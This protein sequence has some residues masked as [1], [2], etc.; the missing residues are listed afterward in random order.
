MHGDV[1]LPIPPFSMNDKSRKAPPNTQ[2]TILAARLKS[3]D[4]NEPEKKALLE[5]LLA[6]D[7]DHLRNAGIEP[8]E[9]K[10]L[11]K[12]LKPLP[13]QWHTDLRGV[14]IEGNKKFIN[15]ERWKEFLGDSDGWRYGPPYRFTH[16]YCVEAAEEKPPLKLGPNVKD[17]SNWVHSL[18]L[19]EPDQESI[20]K[21]KHIEQGFDKRHVPMPTH[22]EWQPFY[23]GIGDSKEPPFKITGL[24]VNGRPL[25]AKPDFILR[26]T[27][28]RII[29]IEIKGSDKTIPIDGWPDL[30]A[31]LWAYGQIDELR[32]AS[33]VL[34]IGEIWWRTENHLIRRGRVRWSRD[35]SQ[36]DTQNRELFEL[37]KGSSK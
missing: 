7:T 16:K 37:Y 33:A 34:L 15:E 18:Y 4:L 27:R 12:K 2:L 9:L 6:L 20:L 3:G 19:G 8:D 36:F 32:N 23:R 11:S 14:F 30:R 10:Y 26:D 25:L 1:L 35:D 29:V 17:F 31:Q 5:K 24:T 22:K 21:G 28:D 13:A